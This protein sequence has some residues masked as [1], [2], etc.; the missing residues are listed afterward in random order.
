MILVKK[1]SKILCLVF[2]LQGKKFSR[3]YVKYVICNNWNILYEDYFYVQK[4]NLSADG[5]QNTVIGMYVHTITSII[6]YKINVIE[7]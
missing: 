6:C 2:L 7:L 3:K 5:G 1:I 4:L